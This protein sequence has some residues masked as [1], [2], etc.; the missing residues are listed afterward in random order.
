MTLNDLCLSSI[1]FE[2]FLDS[3]AYNIHGFTNAVSTPE[4]DSS[5]TTHLRWCHESFQRFPETMAPRLVKRSKK[6]LIYPHLVLYNGYRDSIFDYAF[7]AKESISV[8]SHNLV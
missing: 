5:T 8:S 4:T 7:P 3:D 1:F 6:V 2:C